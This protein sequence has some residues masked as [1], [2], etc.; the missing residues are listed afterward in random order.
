MYKTKIKSAYH[1]QHLRIAYPPVAI[2]LVNQLKY[3]HRSFLVNIV[4]GAKPNKI[5]PID[6]TFLGFI[7]SGQGA[8]IGRVLIVVFRASEINN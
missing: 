2:F 6:K 5:G 4:T 1:T 7:D 3:F 8:H